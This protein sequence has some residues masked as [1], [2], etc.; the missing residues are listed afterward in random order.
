[1]L[2]SNK[3]FIPFPKMFMCFKKYV[4]DIFIKKLY[5]VKKCVIKK[6]FRIIKKCLNVNLNNV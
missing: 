5:N 2:N 6:L 1:M 3:C 4:R